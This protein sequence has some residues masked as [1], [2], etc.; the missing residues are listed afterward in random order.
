MSSSKFSGRRPFIATAFLAAGLII[1]PAAR[2]ATV[3]LLNVS[4][5]PTREL[6]EDYNRAFAAY[7]KTK[8]GDIVTIN[9]SHG[10]SGKQEPAQGAMRVRRP[11]TN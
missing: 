2:S 7:W 4:Y 1:A 9:Q 3:T 5:D 8:T 10:G 6:Y 11:A